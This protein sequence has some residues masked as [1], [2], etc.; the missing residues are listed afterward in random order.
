MKKFFIGFSIYFTI[1]IMMLGICGIYPLIFIG[2]ILAY[3]LHI[4]FTNKMTESEILEC[5][6]AYWLEKKFPNNP[7]FKIDED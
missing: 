5:I 7:L 6:G 2:A 3:F 4:K 1:M